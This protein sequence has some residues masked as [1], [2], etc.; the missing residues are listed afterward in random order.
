M[1][2]ALAHEAAPAAHP[3]P[4]VLTAFV[5]RALSGGEKQKV[6]DHLARCGECR[7]IVF[8]ASSAA[9]QPVAEEQ[10]WMAASA[11][12]RISPVL[13]AKAH[14]PQAMAS[15]SPAKASRTRWA[16]KMIWAMPVA[17]AVLLVAG[18]LVRQRFGAVRST[19]QPAANVASKLSEPAPTE[20]QHVTPRQPLVGTAA[21][22][23]S[24]ER[25]TKPTR[26]KSVPSKSL[27][28]LAMG[29]DAS[30]VANEY[31]PPQKVSP[32]NA[33]GGPT[34]T[35]AGQATV[36]APVA[37]RANSFAA[38]EA[39]RDKPEDT[40]TDQLLVTPRVSNRASNAM[41]LQW[42]VTADGHLE[43]FS[44]D[45]WTRAF[46]N[47]AIT[48]RAVS[49]L[50]GDVWAGGNGGAL[51]HSGDGGQHWSKVSLATSSGTETGA[52]VSIQFDDP[53]HGAVITESGWRYRTSDGGIT[54]TRE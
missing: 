35:I 34:L 25:Q 33:I 50:G 6:T 32:A 9:D 42:R 51:F 31:P 40:A 18:L 14:A 46:A 41:H 45:G 4:D 37:P 24:P 21:A 20:P 30:R 5:E 49:V 2:N 54:W 8:L 44:Q 47:Q 43:H 26:A 48:F 36:A 52:I 3:S 10:D 19:S 13:Q 23:P 17:A 12:P 11:V 28:T 1:L 27:D 53:Q 29:H 38:S 22:I 7:K 15:A 39:E 16:P